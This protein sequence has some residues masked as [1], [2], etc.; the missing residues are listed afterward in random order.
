MNLCVGLEQEIRT[1][2]LRMN[3]IYMQIDKYRNINIFVCTCF[4]LVF[5]EG[6]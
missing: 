3:S 5:A 6:N 1:H 4:L 2:E